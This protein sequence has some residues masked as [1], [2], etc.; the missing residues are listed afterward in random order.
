MTAILMI[1]L[2][3]ALGAAGA[4]DRFGRATAFEKAGNYEAAI[5]EYASFLKAHPQDALAPTAAMAIGN[6]SF[7]ALENHTAAVE[8]Y[9]RVLKEYP[10]SSW[11]AEAARRKAECLEVEENWEG[12]GEAYGEALKLC[13]E[14]DNRPP[15]NWVNEVSLAAADCY[16]ELGDRSRV[17]ETYETVLKSSM[18]PPAAATTLYRLADSYE[19]NAQGEKAARK[20]AELIEDYPFSAEYA[21]AIGKR[22]CIDQYLDFEWEHYLT[23]T[24]TT[25]D[26]QTRDFAAAIPRCDDIITRSPNEKL[27]LCAEYRKI[28]AETVIAGDYTEGAGRLESFLNRIPD[29]RAFPNAQRQLLLF[30]QTAGLERQVR[31]SPDDG[32]ALQQLGEQ[33][34]RSQSLAKG[35]D[36]L[37]KARAMDPDNADI[38]LSLGLAYL[39]TGQPEAAQTA[40][41]VYFTQNPTNTG[42]LNQVGYT[43]LGLGDVE[44]AL[45][46]FVKYVK[47]G[48]DDANAHDSYGEG[49]LAA[50][51]VE[52][53]EQE[54]ETAVRIDSTF[55]N[56][57]FMLGTIYQQGS[58]PE[59]AVAA[60]Q[61]FLE[62][63][64]ADPRAERAHT[65]LRELRA[66]QAAD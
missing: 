15:P 6:I 62:L 14:G 18:P 57:Y 19:S 41:G 65:A 23:Y 31:E 40:F 64:P 37:E 43:Y 49:L 46:Y 22:E 47:A 58:K 12:A 38:A 48:P 21:Q 56:A 39:N 3:L 11:A 20:Y 55:F 53:A 45:E 1:L 9:D 63:A 52:E 44:T 13:G 60:Y 34:L 33:Y 27:K 30:Q 42:V 32:A 51:R 17:I 26:F 29:R 25:Q 61:K 8:A 50:G 66:A 10:K 54:Y 5:G 16:Y 59:Q 36:A 24:Q 7:L 2:C 35:V 28:V 4:Q